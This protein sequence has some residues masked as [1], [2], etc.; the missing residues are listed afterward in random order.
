MRLLE[1]IL[2]GALEF[3]KVCL[4]KPLINVCPDSHIYFDEQNISYYFN[5]CYILTSKFFEVFVEPWSRFP[6]IS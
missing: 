5:F 3:V 6:G 1:L 4:L 2:F